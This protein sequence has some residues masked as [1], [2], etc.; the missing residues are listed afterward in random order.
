[1]ADVV[2][3]RDIR[4]TLK[5]LIT[6]NIEDLSDEGSIIFES[7][8]DIEESTT[9]RLT[10]FLYQ[11]TDNVSLRN[12]PGSFPSYTQR[13][14]PPLI[15][16]LHFLFVPY[17]QDRE[18][19]IIVMERLMQTL[20]DNAVLR[21]DVLQGSLA[22]SGNDEIRITPKTLSLDDLNKLW[23][24]FPNKAFRLSKSYMISP[25]YIPSEVIDDVSRGAESVIA[26][27]RID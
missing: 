13:Q 4:N 12:S 14:A 22:I 27:S 8:G 2:V 3:L 11:I 20:Y 16:D 19:E 17:A 1:M 26:T 21:G 6:D 15:V 25:V 24:T 10:A 5:K 9:T 7:P 18:K 23:S